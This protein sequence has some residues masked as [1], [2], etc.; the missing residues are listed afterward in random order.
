MPVFESD[1][2]EGY[3]VELDPVGDAE[4]P[5]G[6]AEGYGDAADP[7]GDAADPVGDAADPIDDAVAP[8]GDAV[9]PVGGAPPRYP[10]V[11]QGRV[12]IETIYTYRNHAQQYGWIVVNPGIGVVEYLDLTIGAMPAE[13]GRDCIKLSNHPVPEV[14]RWVVMRDNAINNAINLARARGR[15]A[16]RIAEIDAEIDA[17][18]HHNA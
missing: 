8:V 15:I 12:M 17:G 10:P 9:A 5:V 2:D 14:A 7:V 3:D 16:I 13:M 1:S 18:V 4:D 6:D 11:V